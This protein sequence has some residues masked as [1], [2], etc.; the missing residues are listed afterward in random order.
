MPWG[1]EG[2]GGGAGEADDLAGRRRAAAARERARGGA[3]RRGVR[4]GLSARQAVPYA[5]TL[6]RLHLRDARRQE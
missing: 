4:C 3:A 5:N 1:R 6:L 2:A